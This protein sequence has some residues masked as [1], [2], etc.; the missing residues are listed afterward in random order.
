MATPWLQFAPQGVVKG[1]A[2]AFGARPACRVQAICGFASLLFE[3]ALE[4]LLFTLLTLLFGAPLLLE[5]FADLAQHVGGC[6]GM[7][8]GELR[9]GEDKRAGEDAGATRNAVL[10]GKVRYGRVSEST[11]NIRPAR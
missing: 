9:A 5:D 7:G 3:A 8:G 2:G 6:C 11:R 1:H 4:C 10:H